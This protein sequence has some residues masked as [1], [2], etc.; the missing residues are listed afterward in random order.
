MIESGMKESGWTFRSGDIGYKILM[1]FWVKNGLDFRDKIG[2][3]FEI[4]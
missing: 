2:R 1:D 4:K 3:T